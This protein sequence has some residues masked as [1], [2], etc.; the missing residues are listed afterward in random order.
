MGF[1][2]TDL[3]QRGA[4]VLHATLLGARCV[5]PEI[6]H[7]ETHT[8]GGNKETSQDG[9]NTYSKNHGETDVASSFRKASEVARSSRS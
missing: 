6:G 2:V 5:T 8:F 4:F 1:K 9:T 3:E 7:L